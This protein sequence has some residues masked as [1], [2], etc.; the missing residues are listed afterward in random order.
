[1]PVT[2]PPLC[3]LLWYSLACHCAGMQIVL[4]AV[5]SCLS[6]EDTLAKN[7]EV[8]TELPVAYSACH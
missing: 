8:K 3:L 6:A 4:V 1:M 5:M 7:M 2:Q